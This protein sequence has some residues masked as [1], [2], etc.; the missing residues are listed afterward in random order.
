MTL[1][2]EIYKRLC[3]MSYRTFKVTY[4]VFLE[5]TISTCKTRLK[6]LSVHNARR[7]GRIEIIFLAK[8]ES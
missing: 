3:K 2:S 1:I 7:G 5:L 4:P 6:N 8:N